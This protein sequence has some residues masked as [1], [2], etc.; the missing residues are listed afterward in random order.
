MEPTFS[1]P[2]LRPHDSTVIPLVLEEDYT[3]VYT[4][5]CNANAY[6]SVCGDI[7]VPCYWNK[8]YFAVIDSSKNG[9][10][11][12]LVSFSGRKNGYSLNSLTPSSSGTVLAS[13]TIMNFDE[14]GQSCG[15]YNAKTVLTY[16]D[17]WQ[18]QAGGL[19]QDLWSLCW[20]KFSFTEGDRG[21]LIG[22]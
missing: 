2:A 7:C 13:N 19:K 15:A 16:P 9:G 3:K 22:G 12:F 11:T 10:D 5:D 21:R 1:V 17:N 6:T 18:M 8:W 14:Q 4:A 20:L